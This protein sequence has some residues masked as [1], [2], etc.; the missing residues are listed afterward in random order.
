MR[1]TEAI[2]ALAVATVADGRSPRTAAGYRQ[3]LGALVAYLGDVEAHQVTGQDLRRFVANLRQQGQRY[4]SHVYRP[5]LDGPLS[6]ATVAGAVRAIKRLF[7]FLVEDGILTDNPARAL[8]IQKL[9]KGREP[10]A[11]SLDDLLAML[12]ATAG[13]DPAHVRDR[14]LLLFLADTGC[15]VGG[16]VG[17][18]LAD[19][20]IA[21]QT[22]HVIEK[23]DKRR[24]VYFTERTAEA[25]ERWLE[26]RP[27]GSS[28]VFVRVDLRQTGQGLTALGVSEIL[29]RIG[30][31]AGVTGP[32]NPHSFRHAF[33][34]EYL[35]NGGDLATLADLLGHADISTTSQ[36]LIFAPNELQRKHDRF[37]PVPKLDL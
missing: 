25:L 11:I 6:P 31:R 22:A 27:A 20:D 19:L 17:L 23:G 16:L 4:E 35:S 13:G 5:A 28:L 33:A 36:Y 1:L 29:R 12:Q 34:R 30:R 15:R 37:S 24:P 3:R 10:K 7:S 18:R 32:H 14:A 8:K 9:P 2:E 26:L 21:Q